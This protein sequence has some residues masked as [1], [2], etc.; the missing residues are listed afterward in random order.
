MSMHKVDS[1]SSRD[2][3]RGGRDETLERLAGFLAE[4][5]SRG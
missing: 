5:Q 4:L 2:G 1:T 3:Y